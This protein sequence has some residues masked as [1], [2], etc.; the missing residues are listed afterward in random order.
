VP[1]SL[2]LG[3]CLVYRCGLGALGFLGFWGQLGWSEHVL[4]AESDL[5]CLFGLFWGPSRFWGVVA[6][7]FALSAV[8]AGPIGVRSGDSRAWNGRVEGLE[9]WILVSLAFHTCAML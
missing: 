6:V 7:R 8:V 1:V 3:G 5:G 4:L 2:G 9:D